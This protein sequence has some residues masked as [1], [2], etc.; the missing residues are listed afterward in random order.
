MNGGRPMTDNDLK[1]SV[2]RLLARQLFGVLGTRDDAGRPHLSIVSF[3]SADDLKS[4]VFA[5]PRSTRK[6][7]YLEKRP[8]AAFFSDDRRERIDDLM[9][10]IGVEAAG[11]ARE[12]ADS[13]R[14]PYRS[15]YLAKY[16]ELAEF[17]D[18]PGTALMRIAVQRYDVVDH[19]QHVLVLR[20][21]GP[22]ELGADGTEP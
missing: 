15:L 9:D 21:G 19:F 2:K 22:G 5:T 12:L 3:V 17:V 18:A 20:T 16:P 11:E 14:E 13:E 1:I 7:A 6:Y 10:V 4:L 8:E